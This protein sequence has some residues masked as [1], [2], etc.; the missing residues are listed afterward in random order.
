MGVTLKKQDWGRGKKV[1]QEREL[2]INMWG[3]G[4][5][6][7]HGAVAETGLLREAKR[8]NRLTPKTAV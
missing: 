3:T 7:V 2:C 5:T 8:P 4:W 6:T 1:L